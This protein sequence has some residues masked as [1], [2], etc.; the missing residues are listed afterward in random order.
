MDRV[1]V[2]IV[3]LLGSPRAK[4]NSATLARCFGDAAAARGAQVRFFNLNRLTY[5]GCQAC[6]VCKTKLEHCVLEDDLTPVLEAVREAD[7]VV[8]ASPIYYSDLSAQ[9]KGFV[10]RSYSY[11]VPDYITNPVRSRLAPGKKLVM[12]LTQGNPDEQLF[13][14][15]FPRYQALLRWEGFE[16]AYL[17]RG[18]GLQGEEDILEQQAVIRRAEE[19]G[20]ELAG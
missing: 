3:C 19:L 9:L 4:G 20:R 2:N 13:A 7:V 18:V 10:D 6:M 15:V 1:G 5:R 11:L 12:I 14:D 16:D 17:I 8:M